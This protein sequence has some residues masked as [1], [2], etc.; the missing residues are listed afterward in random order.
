MFIKITVLC[1][2]YIEFKNINNNGIDFV[3]IS[4]FPKYD[5]KNE[6]KFTEKELDLVYL[7]I[8][9]LI[10]STYN[11]IQN[12]NSIYYMK[13]IPKPMFIYTILK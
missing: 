5:T 8:D 11:S 1:N 10:I 13:N 9:K 3:L 2:Y 12:Y 4:M 7:R 6:I